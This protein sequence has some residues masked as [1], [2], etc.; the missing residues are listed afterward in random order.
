M[1]GWPK[2]RHDKLKARGEKVGF[3]T[4]A[5][6]AATKNESVIAAMEALRH[7]NPTRPRRTLPLA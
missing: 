2:L 5:A 4:S 3:I 7:P 6:E 1:G